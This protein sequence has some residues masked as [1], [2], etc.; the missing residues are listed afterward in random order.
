VERE[1]LGR[2]IHQSRQPAGDAGRQ[3]GIRGFGVLNIA[4][5]LS[6]NFL[7]GVGWVLAPHPIISIISHIILHIAAVL[8][9]G[10]GSVHLPPHY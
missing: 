9:G 6:G 4:D 3:P 7:V 5:P 10:E 1:T 8:A 2:C